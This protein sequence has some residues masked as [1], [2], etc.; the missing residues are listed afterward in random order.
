LAGRIF[1]KG[2]TWNHTHTHTHTHICMYIHAHIYVFIHTY[3]YMYTHTHKPH[4][5]QLSTP[6]ET[7]TLL[8]L[9]RE[10]KTMSHCLFQSMQDSAIGKWPSYQKQ[11][12]DL[13]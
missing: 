3:M 8:A 2:R 9:F 4:D 12:T 1:S 5:Q 10:Q 6:V 7:H 13:V 11:S